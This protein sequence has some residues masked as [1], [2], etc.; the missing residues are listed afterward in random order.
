MTV[1]TALD[2]WKAI[3][4]K[5]WKKQFFSNGCKK[6]FWKKQFKFLLRS[7]HF[8]YTCQQR[9]FSKNFSFFWVIFRL[10]VDDFV[11]SFLLNRTFLYL[12]TFPWGIDLQKKNEKKS[13]KNNV[14]P[15]PENKTSKKLFGFHALMETWKVEVLQIP[16]GITF[17]FD[18]NFDLATITK[19]VSSLCCFFSFP[20]TDIH[21]A[22]ELK[23]FFQLFTLVISV[24][25]SL[26]NES[27]GY[28]FWEG[29]FLQ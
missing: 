21:W 2:I 7:P 5:F 12:K 6:Y 26:E 17:Q 27:R 10:Y 29:S 14:L 11:P 9:F 22:T 8:L 19:K 23:F 1:D 28:C 18:Q 4:Y 15:T 24:R 13:N 16:I 20:V 3:L 25:I